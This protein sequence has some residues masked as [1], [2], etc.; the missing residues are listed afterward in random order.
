ML[1]LAN[2]RSFV[3]GRTSYYDFDPI[4]L[5]QQAAVYLKIIL[6]FIQNISAYALVDTGSPYC[7]INSALLNAAG[8]DFAAGEPVTLSTR[9]G[10]IEGTIQRLPIVV[11]AEEG[12]QLLIEAS[13][14]VS[15]H[16][17][18]GN[19]LGYSG[20]LERLRFAIDPSSNNF[21]FGR[22]E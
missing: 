11:A 14:F 2:S 15:E 19:F 13:V 22:A 21:Y 20:F 5:R 8:I 10:R 18:Y 1:F 12:E 16:W 6:P 17:S 9:V 4:G 7:V 3:T